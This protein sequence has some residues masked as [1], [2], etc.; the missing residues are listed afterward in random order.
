MQTDRVVLIPGPDDEVDIVREIYRRFIE[1]GETERA[2]ASA[3]N[4]RGV[5]TDKDRPW[6][7]A[8]I[9]QILTNPKYSGAN[10]YNRRSYKL[11]KRRVKNPP[12]MWIRNEAA[13]EPL[14]IPAEFQRAQ[15]IMSARH[16]RYSDD[17]MLEFLRTLL[18][19]RG[20]LSG[21]LIDETDGLPS[22][23]AY[24][25]RFKSLLR[26]YS[27][28]GYTPER[29][30]AYLT[31]NRRLREKHAICV[32]ALISA[33]GGVGA[34]VAQDRETGLLTINDEMSTSVILARCREPRPGEYRWLLRLVP[35]LN[36]D[37]TVAV[38]LAPGNED[39]LDY[40]LFPRI[41]VLAERLCLGPQNGFV[42]D[43]YRFDDLSFF[44]DLARQHSLPEVT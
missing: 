5:A 8:D 41:D 11:K 42:I 12:D 38:R 28:I 21:I 6:A 43:V 30:Y 27:L 16:R 17:E 33:L 24:Q 22:S 13:F 32:E 7:S 3:L 19:S 9:Y 15:E 10:V 35:S 44:L 18:A 26:A 29:D 40:Y 36:P 20:R 31:L 4:A 37:I 1:D 25:A 23:A 34:T 39:V 2:I 14:I